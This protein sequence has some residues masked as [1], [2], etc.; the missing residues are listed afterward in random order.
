MREEFLDVLR[1]AIDLKDPSGAAKQYASLSGYS[2]LTSKGIVDA[3]V[4]AYKAIEKKSRATIKENGDRVME[5]SRHPV[6]R[7]L[8]AGR[9]Y[10]VANMGDLK[11]LHI[12][13][14]HHDGIY[15]DKN[16]GLHIIVPKNKTKADNIV[17]ILDNIRQ[18]WEAGTDKYVHIKP[19][20]S[21]MVYEGKVLAQTQNELTYE[22]DGDDEPVYE[23][24]EEGQDE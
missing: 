4:D 17:R 10:I 2:Y 15:F 23:D 5:V 12:P 14:A 6:L 11:E 1:R 19:E 24:L 22:E 21:G 13:Y 16:T 7:L 3:A 18:N 20:L 9:P 8:D